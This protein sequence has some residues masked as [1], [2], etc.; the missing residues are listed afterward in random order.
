MTIHFRCS[1]CSII[2]KRQDSYCQHCRAA[3]MRDW[4]KTQRVAV[5]QMRA[6][7]AALREQLQNVSQQTL[8]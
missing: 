2:T 4:R 8:T 5:E 3:Y 1:R 6:E 7:N